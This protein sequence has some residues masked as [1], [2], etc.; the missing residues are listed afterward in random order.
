MNDV[1][2]YCANVTLISGNNIDAEGMKALV[3]TLK[4]LSQLMSLDL[5][6]E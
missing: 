5:G 4:S 2:L 1:M 3:V 6:G